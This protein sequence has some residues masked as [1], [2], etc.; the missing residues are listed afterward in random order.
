MEEIRKCPWCKNIGI[1]SNLTELATQWKCTH[2]QC[3]Y[4]EPKISN[5]KTYEIKTPPAQQH[6]QLHLQRCIFKQ[7]KQYI[8]EEIKLKLPDYE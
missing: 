4:N 3:W 2:K 6:N 1:D 5:S 7:A 8:Q